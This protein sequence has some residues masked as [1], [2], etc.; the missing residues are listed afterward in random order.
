MAAG[1][2]YRRPGQTQVLESAAL[3]KK[4]RVADAEI[5]G[6]VEA[7]RQRGLQAEAYRDYLRQKEGR[8]IKI[9]LDAQVAEKMEAKK[10]AEEQFVKEKAEVDAV[11]AAIEAEDAREAEAREIKEAQIKEFAAGAAA[12]DDGMTDRSDKLGKGRGATR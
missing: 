1:G 6:L 10:L 8:T 2:E 7:E 11:V 12:I 4:E 3:L 9:A 5:A